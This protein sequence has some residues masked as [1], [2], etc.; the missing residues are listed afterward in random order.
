MEPPPYT[1]MRIE[2]NIKSKA[3]H[4]GF[5]GVGIT[6][7]EPVPHAGFLDTWL[8]KG[9][10]GSMAWMERTKQ[11]RKDIREKYPW[12]K[13]IVCV[14]QNY[15]NN[16]RPDWGEAHPANRIASYA[17]GLDY[18][19]VL[20]T[21]LEALEV[22][23]KEEGGRNLEAK[24]YT[25]T[26]PFL[27]REL[28][29]RAGLGWVG[30]NTCL[31]SPSHGSHVFLGEIVT[32]LD[33]QFDTPMLDHCGT[34]RLC[35]DACPT[36]AFDEAWMLNSRKCISY[37]TIETRGPLPDNEQAMI[38]DHLFGCDICQDV[39]PHNQKT[40]DTKEAAYLTKTD[41]KSL[42]WG[43]CEAMD[44][45]IFDAYFKGTPIRRLKVENFRR[46]AKACPPSGESV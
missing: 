26:G 9:H 32:S 6:S 45:D 40:R 38:D 22:F 25:D 10:A 44:K 20:L 37:L 36:G 15:K 43:L 35:L 33:L 30:K 4:L 23:L 7:A 46:N 42:T 21:K 19:D 2:D 11:V 8:L 12:A 41:Y 28:A 17:R 5:E 24:S 31:I 14:F 13:S 29:Q 3:C 34:C 27:E 39:C 16:G 18:H 1:M